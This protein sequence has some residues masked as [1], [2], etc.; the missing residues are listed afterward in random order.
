MAGFE[1]KKV[2]KC[3]TVLAIV[4]GALAVTTPSFAQTA[5]EK[6]GARAAANAGA[7]AFEAGNFE[8]AIDLFQRAESV[9]HSPVHELYIAR[10]MVKVG[11]FVEAR[12]LLLKIGRENDGDIVD[13]AATEL[14]A[15]EPRVPRLTLEVKGQ[16]GSALQISVNEREFPSALVGIAQPF[17][18]GEHTVVTSDGVK[19]AT[20]TFTLEEGQ[21]QTVEVDLEQ[22]EAVPIAAPEPTEGPADAADPAEDSVQVTSSG[23][24]GLR[25]GSYVAMGLGLAGVGVGT[26]FALQA[27]GHASDANDLCSSIDEREGTS[28][29]AGR[30]EAEER[31]VNDFD[32]KHKSA[33]TLSI[34]GFAAGGA[35]LATGV[36]LFFLSKPK[37]TE[38]VKRK[39]LSVDPVIGLSYLGV[40]G[41]F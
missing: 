26:V 32:D 16:T 40:E 14:D 3:L 34:V 6:A 38:S 31:E 39:K 15:L 4:V 23:T 10:S 11:R 41:T 35:L 25:I 8:K 2:Q 22:G 24:N 1:T 9:I 12:E 7:D 19:K 18:P 27:G 29:C 5:E 30:T 17:D 36:T 37:S 21:S 13:E 20:Q 28:N 33:K